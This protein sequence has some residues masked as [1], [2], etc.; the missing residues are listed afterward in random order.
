M[1]EWNS[2]NVLGWDEA[3]EIVEGFVT[4]EGEMYVAVY[5]TVSAVSSYLYEHL[6]ENVVR[7][8]MKLIQYTDICRHVMSIVQG[9]KSLLFTRER[10]VS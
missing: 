2:D 5:H 4:D 6:L 7:D 9:L 3:D 1:K 10:S 8:L